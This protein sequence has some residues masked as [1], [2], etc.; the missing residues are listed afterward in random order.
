MWHP[1]STHFS[2]PNSSDKL[3]HTYSYDI[4][5]ASTISCNFSHWSPNMILYFCNH[6]W[7]GSTSWLTAIWIIIQP[8]PTKFKLI[9]SFGNSLIWRRRV[10]QCVLKIGMNFFSF[11]VFFLG[12]T[13][14]L[15]DFSIFKNNYTGTTINRCPLHSFLSKALVL[16]VITPEGLLGI[17]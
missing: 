10:P 6:F 2:I 11:Y 16:N 12:S 3:W 4:P 8:L 1:S 17:M 13:L 5:T 9:G 7:D 14:S 15:L